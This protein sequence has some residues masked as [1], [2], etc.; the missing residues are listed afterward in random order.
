ELGAAALIAGLPAELERGDAAEGTVAGEP[1]PPGLYLPSSERLGH[2]LS[3]DE[4]FHAIPAGSQT[5]YARPVSG[6]FRPTFFSEHEFQVVRRLVRLILGLPSREV[7]Q[8]SQ[9][10]ANESAE[11]KREDTVESVAQWIDVQMASA[12]AVRNAAR[13][14]SPEHRTVAAHYYGPEVVHRQETAEPDTIW[15]EGLTWL[16]Q[17]SHQK[18]GAEFLK[19]TGAQEVEI[20]EVAGS[21]LKSEAGFRFF[22]L[23]KRES[24]RGY[25]TSRQGLRELDYRGNS[26]Y[27]ESPGCPSDGKP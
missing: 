22:D 10:G 15:R 7:S 24:V 27:P 3:S 1:L 17:H 20:L 21:R 26:F 18:Y 2:V 4:L 13:S 14:L 5:D 12:A 11:G 6:L 16:D 19:L 9:N 23:I 25:Y 8:A